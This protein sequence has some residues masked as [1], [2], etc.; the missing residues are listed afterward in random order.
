VLNLSNDYILKVYWEEFKTF[1]IVFKDLYLDGLKAKCDK[2][3]NLEKTIFELFKKH[4]IVLCDNDLIDSLTKYVVESKE[5]VNIECKICYDKNTTHILIHE[6]HACTI[7][8]SC[9]T[10]FNLNSPCPFCRMNIDNKL[11]LTIL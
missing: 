6:K 1:R 4:E 8:E 2:R 11:K 7:C 5:K 9:M 3:N 10:K